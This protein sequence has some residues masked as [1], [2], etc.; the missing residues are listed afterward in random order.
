MI[1]LS[2]CRDF[3]TLT[4]GSSEASP[5]KDFLPFPPGTHPDNHQA[6]WF[7]KID[8]AASGETLHVYKG[9]YWEAKDQGTWDMCPDIF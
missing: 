8:D 3:L 1:Y 7:E 5:V 9:G 6:L 4:S 2:R